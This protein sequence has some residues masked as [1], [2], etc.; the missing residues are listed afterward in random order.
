MRIEIRPAVE[1][2]ME[3]YRRTALASL[4]LSP[5]Q[6]PPAA[7]QAISPGMTLCAF[8]DGH[9][10][11]S[12]AAWPLTMRLNG[13]AAPTAGVTFVGTLPQFRQLGCLRQVVTRHFELLHERGE[14]PLA[15]L[16]ASQAAIYQRY[17]YGVVS[18]RHAYR[19]EPRHLQFTP[20][21]NAVQP[22]GTLR[23][24][25]EQEPETL[26]NL[27]R[28]YCADRTGHLHRSQ[29][30]WAAGPLAPPPKSGFL[31]KIIYEE[32]GV[33]QGYMLYTVAPQPV[34]D[35]EPWQRVTVRDLCWLTPTAYAALWQHLRAMGLAS[36]I[37]M[38]RVPVD[39]PLPHLLLE[40]R[41]L[42]LA[43]KDGLLARV[44]DVQRALPLRGYGADGTITFELLD[45]LCPWNAGRWR[46]EASP[47]GAQVQRTT[48]SAQAVLPVDTLA[49]LLFGQISATA[50]ARMGRMTVIEE[51]AL[52][53]WDRLLA[54]R[55]KPF[56]P[57]FF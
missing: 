12:Y 21:A 13:R 43:A 34:P 54:T 37:E 42:N 27:Y 40:P 3:A 46:L 20:S 38:P 7:I 5:E 9:L 50:A 11:T 6:A 44:V 53:L 8:V 16:L 17:G 56:C 14:Q 52:G 57:D 35:G 15:A 33:P 23:E 48:Q 30:T 25:G 18:T 28:A 39:D 22:M 31:F 1:T 32:K 49:M 41:R 55:H 10:A 4:V 19:I 45:G 51:K 36:H 26:K 47:Q 29:P 24:L 2:E